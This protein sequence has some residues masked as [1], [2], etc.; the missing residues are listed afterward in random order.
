MR[1]AKNED[2]RKNARYRFPAGEPPSILKH[3][4]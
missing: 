3:F 2:G 4:Q 1:I